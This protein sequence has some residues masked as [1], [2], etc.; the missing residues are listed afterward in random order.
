[1]P[2][3]VGVR[4][5]RNAGVRRADLLA[6]GASLFAEHGYDG[7]TVEQIIGRAGTSKGG[8]YHHFQSKDDLLE[9]M[10]AQAAEQALR[11][12][13]QV[14]SAP[15]LDAV[16]RL[17]RFL[18]RGRSDAG[19][20]REMATY[21]AIFRPENLGLYHRLHRAVSAVLVAP[22][23]RIIEQGRAEGAI[24][25]EHPAIAAEIV[26]TLGPLTHDAIAGIAEARTKDEFDLAVAA[27]RERLIQQA[28]AVDRILGLPDGTVSYWDEASAADWVF[29]HPS[30]A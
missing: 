12:L 21:G 28:I 14:V 19:N 26:L 10:A 2:A 15:G 30:G 27:L 4:R 22:L 6:A 16:Q 23:A 20:A 24:R 18:Q 13:D 25:C 29:R 3:K 1:M 7:T 11:G 17:N 5:V 9:A 8:F